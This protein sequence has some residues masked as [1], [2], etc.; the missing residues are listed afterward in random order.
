VPQTIA[1]SASGL[2]SGA[3]ATF[4]P[5]TVLAGDASTLTLAADTTTPE[6][7]FTITVTGTAASATHTVDVDLTVATLPAHSSGGCGCGV[8]QNADAADGAIFLLALGF[9]VRR[10]RTVRPAA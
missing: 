8:D 1:F 7:T 5:T 10:R 9:V 6:G 3:T 2:P 4:V